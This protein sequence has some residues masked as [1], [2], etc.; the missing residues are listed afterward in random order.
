M[1]LYD[2]CDVYIFAKEP[3]FQDVCSQ[4]LLDVTDGGQDACSV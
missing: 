3:S 2:T 4:L 1:L